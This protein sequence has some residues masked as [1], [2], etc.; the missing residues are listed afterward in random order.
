[1][2]V[3]LVSSPELR[4]LKVLFK[5]LIVEIAVLFVFHCVIIEIIIGVLRLDYYVCF[6][7]KLFGNHYGD[8]LGT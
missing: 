8:F 7:K 3:C 4:R 2:P 1:M 5:K 6:I